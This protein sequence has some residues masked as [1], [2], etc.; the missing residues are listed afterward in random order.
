MGRFRVV[1]VL[2]LR[3]EIVTQIR[4]I[5]VLALT[6]CVYVHRVVPVFMSCFSMSRHAARV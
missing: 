3:S 5:I 4:P 1:F 2:A 6:L